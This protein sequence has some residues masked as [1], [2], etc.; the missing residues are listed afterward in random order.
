[1]APGHVS[2]PWGN[3]VNLPQDWPLENLALIQSKGS[4]QGRGSFSGS[5]QKQGGNASRLQGEFQQMW[6]RARTKTNVE[7]ILITDG[8]LRTLCSAGLYDNVC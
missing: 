8:I 7:Y 1:M 2:P 3:R 5:G 4:M 6:P